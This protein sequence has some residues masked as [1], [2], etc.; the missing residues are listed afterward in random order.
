MIA[1]VHRLKVRI[2]A[3]LFAARVDREL[4]E[5]LAYHLERDRERAAEA[6]A[7]E[8]RKK[9]GNLTAIK[10]EA[11]DAWRSPWLDAV[12]RDIA[13]ALRLLRRDPTFSLVAILT[14]ALGVGANTALLSVVRAVVFQTLPFERPSQLVAVVD[15]TTSGG[16]AW[17]YTSLD[18]FDSWRRSAR[19]FETLAAMH[20]CAVVTRDGGLPRRLSAMCVS[21]AFF[22]ML[23]VVPQIGAGFAR[24]SEQPGK[25][26]V[27][28]LSDG[29]WRTQFAG[30]PNVV[31]RT[32]AD[33]SGTGSWQIVGVLPRDFAFAAVKVDVWAPLVDDPASPYRAQHEWLVF[34]RLRDGV[35]MNDAREETAAIAARIAADDPAHGRGWSTTVVPL[36]RFYADRGDTRLTLF[37]LLGA[38]GLLLLAACANLANLVLARTSAR[39]GELALR[40]AIGASRGRLASQLFAES[41]VLG[42]LGGV[43]SLAVAYATLQAL[44]AIAPPLPTFRTSSIHLDATLVLAS[45]ATGT[46]ASSIVAVLSLPSRRQLDASFRGGRAAGTQ[47]ERRTRVA[48]VTVEI[49]LS[50]VLVN[51]AALL[52]SSLQNLSGDRPG[53]ASDHVLTFN[54]CCLRAPKYATQEALS[55]F[56]IAARDR[57]AR[58][59]GV[60]SAA[61]VSGNTAIPLN[62]Q[63][64]GGS[65]PIEVRGQETSRVESAPS[66]DLIFA[67]PH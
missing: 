26:R 40:L 21:P 41:A 13:F 50:L 27:V 7:A 37:V 38:V 58:I 28:L 60:V 10:E 15:R 20:G 9:F 3:F 23:G 8:A 46:L 43:A 22:P 56:H 30:D 59:P 48:L 14:L 12:A 18:R 29:F 16:P 52:V 6:G 1:L 63:A 32:L 39:R 64:L 17:E 25:N 45:I 53:Y 35:S 49:A 24:D 44:S 33:P 51:G 36:Q 61:M 66:A 19:S 62:A 54:V 57:I 5:E 11:R 55:Q 31:G 4:D 2:R 47:R 42:A 65:S 67:G 34:G